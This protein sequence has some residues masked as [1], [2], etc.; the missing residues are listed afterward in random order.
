MTNVGGDAT[1]LVNGFSYQQA[2]SL[3][4]ITPTIG[5]S[6]GGEIVTISGADFLPTSQVSFGANICTVI[7]QSATEISCMTP[8][9]AIEGSVGVIIFNINTGLTSSSLQFFL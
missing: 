8:A 2:P 3:A 1:T 7:N 6:L 4:S 9:S 5:S